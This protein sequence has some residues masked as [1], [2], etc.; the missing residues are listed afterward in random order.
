MEINFLEV[1]SPQQRIVWAYKATGLSRKEIAKEMGVN[2]KYVAVCEK[3]IK[4]KFKELNKQGIIFDGSSVDVLIENQVEDIFNE[5]QLKNLPKKTVKQAQFLQDSTTHTVGKNES[6]AER[7][8]RTRLGVKKQRDNTFIR[9]CT[10]EELDSFQTEESNKTPKDVMRLK[11]RYDYY[12]ATGEGSAEEMANLEIILRSYGVI[13]YTPHVNK[14]NAKT[15]L[16]QR[17][18][19]SD[20]VLVVKDGEKINYSNPKFV[21]KTTNKDGEVERVYII[22][23]KPSKFNKRN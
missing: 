12:W 22:E 16:C 19:V 15:G 3:R 8:M 4:E 13:I 17:A 1:L 20:T 11:A 5:E 14:L 7:R 6:E 21:E 18:M 23:G 10:Q 2:S 9:K